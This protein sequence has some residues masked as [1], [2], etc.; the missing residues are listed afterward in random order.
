MIKRQLSIRLQNE[1]KCLKATNKI[2]K[3]PKKSPTKTH[4]SISVPFRG[5]PRYNPRR[6]SGLGWAQFQLTDASPLATPTLHHPQHPQLTLNRRLPGGPP[7]PCPSDHPFS[8]ASSSLSE[9]SSSH[10][11]H[12]DDISIVT[13]NARRRRH[14]FFIWFW[15]VFFTIFLFECD[16]SFTF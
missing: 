13:G 2:S 7:S 1:Q 6:R 14:L 10:R 12:E 3:I 16:F 5:P 11:S 8:S 9:S 4:K 15:V